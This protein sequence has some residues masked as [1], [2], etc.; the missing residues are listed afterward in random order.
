MTAPGQPGG[1][2]NGAGTRPH[3]TLRREPFSPVHDEDFFYPEAQ[4]AKCLKFL[5]HL[6]PYS[7]VLLLTGPPGSGKSCL[8]QQIITHCSPSWRICR[9]EAEIA[10]DVNTVLQKLAE[11]FL[12][13]ASPE[14]SLEQRI[15]D[16]HK[17]L[18]A[19]R[20]S[21]LAPV[22]I[23]DDAHLVG[24][25]ILHFLA[26]LLDYDDQED[27]L[28]C[29]ILA[30][31][32]ELKERLSVPSLELLRA[33]VGHAFELTPFEEEDTRAYIEH[34][35]AVAGGGGETIFTSAVYQAIHEESGGI[36]GKIN[37]CAMRALNTTSEQPS[38]PSQPRSQPLGAMLGKVKLPWRNMGIAA[39]VLVF[40]AVLIMQDEINQTIEPEREAQDQDVA[41]GPVVA[42]PSPQVTRFPW[43]DPPPGEVTER[44]VVEEAAPP[45]LASE[46]ALDND[47]AIIQAAGDADEENMVQPPADDTTGIDTGSP[48]PATAG[49]AP[50]VEDK[51]EVA[52]MTPAE[53]AREEPVSVSEKAP[54]PAPAETPMETGSI[55]RREDWILSRNPQHFTVQLMAMD[56]SKVK[57]LAG[58]WGIG[59]D[60]AYY[61]TERGLLAV[62]YGDFPSR[63]AAGAAADKLLK[64]GVRGIKPWV[65]TFASL[66]GKVRSARPAAAAGTPRLLADEDSLLQRN[67]RHYTLQLMAMDLDAVTRRVKQW[68][69]ESRIVYFRTLKRDQELVAVTY[70]D[71]A[72]RQEALQASKGLTG[73]IPGIK[74]WIRQFGSIHETI[75]EFRAVSR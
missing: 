10:T 19:Q 65:R 1:Q 42:T 33:K 50:V 25:P 58:E 31:R 57:R 18:K 52:A 45:V 38:S 71:Y 34:R 56:E 49:E 41:A 20:N 14:L 73:R 67:P 28:M 59:D 30:G 62:L 26:S 13:D 55:E 37:I 39:I 21:A 40:A 68:G 64:G 27:R 6:A 72:T 7:D 43:E 23:I 5:L 74:P 16:M 9:I 51:D 22:V 17:M 15:A 60:V 54:L 12:F 66:Q 32:D 48:V 36:P 53:E 46:D 35:I 29:L 44:P 11:V 63:Q 8:I 69:I 70:G 4:R 2:G 75:A 47:Q 24:L 3:L 61:A